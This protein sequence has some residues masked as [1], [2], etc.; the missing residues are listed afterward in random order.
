MKIVPKDEAGKFY[1]EKVEIIN[2]EP[3]EVIDEVT[4][5]SGEYLSAATGMIAWQFIDR[6]VEDMPDTY[7]E[8]AEQCVRL[9]RQ[10][11]PIV[12]AY[13]HANHVGDFILP[14][15][16]M[17]VVLQNIRANGHPNF[18]GGD[19]RGEIHISK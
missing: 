4:Y 18:L 2:K 12:Y 10:H 9:T 11:T 19:S 7:E 14:T 17:D 8:F 3:V 15:G 5:I 6:P 16:T 1:E 13:F